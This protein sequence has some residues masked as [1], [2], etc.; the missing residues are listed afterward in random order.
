M[1]PDGSR[2]PSKHRKQICYYHR[3][4]RDD[5]K[6]PKLGCN[7][8]KTETTSFRTASKQD[9]RN[10]AAIREYVE[11]VSGLPLLSPPFILLL[12]QYPP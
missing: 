4:Y 5:A 10:F 11:T 1:P 9:D 7:Y 2:G 3:T 6:K 12:L 8:Y